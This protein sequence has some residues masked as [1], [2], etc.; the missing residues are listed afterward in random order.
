MNSKNTKIS[1]ICVQK[2]TFSKA[3]TDGHNE[4]FNR[5]TACSLEYWFFFIEH[6]LNDKPLKNI[7]QKFL[8]FETG[9]CQKNSDNKQAKTS[10]QTLF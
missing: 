8:H 9:T 2:A 7:M 6:Q 1:S 10:N 3:V 5:T 4:W